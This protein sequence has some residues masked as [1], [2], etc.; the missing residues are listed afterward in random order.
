[1]NL[2]L[3]TSERTIKIGIEDVVVTVV[4]T[5]SRTSVKVDFLSTVAS[6]SFATAELEP[7]PLVVGEPFAGGYFAGFDLQDKRY[8]LVV[9]PKAVGQFDDVDWKTA[10]ERCAALRTNG[11]EDWRAPTKDEIC[12]I[13]A[14]LGPN[15][16]AA[17]AFKTG[18]PEA[19]DERWYWTSTEFGSV[20]AWFQDFDDGYLGFGG[21]GGDGRVRAV[22]K[23][24]I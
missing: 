12:A 24:L 10:L 20:Y 23:V 8:A 17:A 4:R 3:P 5:P 2:P 1:M 16:T 13:Y 11:F 9:A 15:V 21:K 19:F 22:R 18:Q 14:N 7:L 6:Q